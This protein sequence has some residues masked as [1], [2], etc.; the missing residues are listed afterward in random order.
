MDDTAK[1]L[2]E[3]WSS[4]GIAAYVEGYV[5]DDAQMP[6]ITY[7]LVQPEWRSQASTYARVWYED[8]S[9]KAITAKINDIESRLGEGIQISCGDGFILLFKD[10]TF[11]Q[12]EQT[13]DVRLKVAYLQLIMEV[14]K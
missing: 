3:F 1:T 8:T 6:Y 2:Y 11:V 14:N 12:F 5:P 13:D 4:F 9:Y 10:I 7:R